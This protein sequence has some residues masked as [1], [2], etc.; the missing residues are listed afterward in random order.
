MSRD[1]SKEVMPELRLE[2]SGEEV[3]LHMQEVNTSN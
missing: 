2:E 3:F 1:F